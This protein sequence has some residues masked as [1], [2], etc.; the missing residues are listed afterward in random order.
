MLGWFMEYDLD[1][2][3]LCDAVAEVV[4]A[5]YVNLKGQAI[6]RATKDGFAWFS[7]RGTGY[8]ANIVE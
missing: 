8:C 6:E 1:A 2:L 5:F 3:I 7:V 4:A